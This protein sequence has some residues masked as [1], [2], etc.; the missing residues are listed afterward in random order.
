MIKSWYKISGIISRNF[1]IIS[2]SYW[3]NYS[4][5]NIL[6]AKPIT[7]RNAG[8]AVMPE[9]AAGKN[10]KGHRLAV[11]F[12]FVIHCF[13]SF[14]R[15]LYQ[16]SSSLKKF[17]YIDYQ[18]IMQQSMKIAQTNR[19]VWDGLRRW[20]ERRDKLIIKEHIIISCLY[21]SKTLIQIIE[22]SNFNNFKT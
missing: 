9:Y 21:L 22:I 13:S 18:Y 2:G 14:Q 11:V 7:K 15:L 6:F 4:P 5:R 8:P 3:K 10:E 20:E 19:T 16:Y 17:I 1:R 12:H